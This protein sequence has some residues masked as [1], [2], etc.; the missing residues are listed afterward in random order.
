M[1]RDVAYLVGAAITVNSEPPSVVTTP[2][3][4][5]ARVTAGP[6]TEVT[7]VSATPPAATGNMGKVV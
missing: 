5:G 1:I 7:M 2:T 6:P 3:P 4:L